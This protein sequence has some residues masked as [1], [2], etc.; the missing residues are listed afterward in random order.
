MARLQLPLP[1]LAPPLRQASFDFA[2][3]RLTKEGN[4]KTLDPRLKMSRMTATFTFILFRQG[5]GD[6]GEASIDCPPPHQPAPGGLASATPPQGGSALNRELED[7]LVAD[8]FGDDAFFFQRGQDGVGRA[9]E[10]FGAGEGEVGFDGG[11][12]LSPGS[13]R[14]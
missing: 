6:T 5:R 14:R 10:V 4:T 13:C 11:G 8:G 9:G 12:G 2:Q 7:G 1:P 3:D